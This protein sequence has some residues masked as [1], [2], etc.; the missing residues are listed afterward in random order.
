MNLMEFGVN[1]RVIFLE[2]SDLAHEDNYSSR[3]L[4]DAYV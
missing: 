3:V 2:I 1:A 4:D